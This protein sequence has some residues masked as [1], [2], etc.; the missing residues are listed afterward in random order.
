VCGDIT[1]L[2]LAGQQSN[3]ICGAAHFSQP[4]ST[5]QSGGTSLTLNFCNA[6][7]KKDKETLSMRL[8]QKYQAAGRM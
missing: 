3:L 1:E 5:L 8:F 7:L 4:A 2:M 6:W